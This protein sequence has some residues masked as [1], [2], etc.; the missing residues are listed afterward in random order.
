MPK[1]SASSPKACGTASEAIR[2]APMVDSRT[3]RTAPSSEAA[4]L[5]SHTYDS[6]ANHSAARI[7]IPSNSRVHPASWETNAL[8][9][10]IA[11]TKTRSKKSSSGLTG[12]SSS[13]S[14]EAMLSSRPRRLGERLDRGA[15]GAE[16]GGLAQL[17]GLVG[18]LPREVVV[19]A[20][21]VP[22]GGGLL[23]DR[24]VQVQRV[25][26]GAR[27]QVEVLVDELLDLAAADLLG[28]ER[29]DHDRHRVRHAD[30]VGDLDLGA[31]GE[32]GGDDVLGHVAGRVGGRAID[33][34]RVLAAERAAA[35]AG[36]AAVGV[37]D[38]LAPRKAA[39]A[40]RAADHE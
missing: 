34:R 7:A 6:H 30:G 9:W 37:D 4:V 27:A 29:L 10:V 25:A 35:V 1:T 18:A 40:H 24:A 5:A 16:A 22:V 23:V 15:G 39:V 26:E 28:A 3:T 8:T 14:T 2:S 21:E 17:L 11:K 36:H 38:D 19:L 13:S 20:A 31:L 32:A 12:C 33:L